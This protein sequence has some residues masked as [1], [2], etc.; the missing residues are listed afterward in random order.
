MHPKQSKNPFFKEI[1]EI[2]MVGVDNVVVL[3]CAL[4]ATTKKGCQPFGARKTPRENPG[5]AY[6]CLLYTSDAADE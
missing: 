1:G 4:R 2:W 5:Y 3:A 6:A